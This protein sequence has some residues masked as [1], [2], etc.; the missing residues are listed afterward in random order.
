MHNNDRLAEQSLVF[1]DKACLVCREEMLRLKT[2]DKA[3]RMQLIDISDT[4]FDASAWGLKQAAVE[5]AM[6]ARTPD[7]RWLIGMPAIRHA[8]SLAGLGW[9]MAASG[10]PVIDRVADKLYLR[11]AANRHAISR[12]FAAFV[13]A[14][15]CRDGQCNVTDHEIKKG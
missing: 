9:V 15:G 4:A 3:N 11:F 10:W 8:Y 12:G 13:P 14:T 2:R 5:A 6:H 1:Y 7:G